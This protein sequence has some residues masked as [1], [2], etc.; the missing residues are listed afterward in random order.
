[1]GLGD[2]ILECYLYT[3]R[4]TKGNHTEHSEAHLVDCMD[5][6]ADMMQKR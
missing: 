1:M 6:L 5:E 3:F 4:E 2:K